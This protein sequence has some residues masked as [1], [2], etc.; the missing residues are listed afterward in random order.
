MSVALKP[1]RRNACDGLKSKDVVVEMGCSRRLAEL[2]FRVVTGRSI[3][4]EILSVRIERAKYLLEHSEKSIAEIAAAC[5][6]GSANAL[7]KVFA[8]ETGKNPLAWR[9]RAV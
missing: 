9:K 3:L 6:Y 8:V 5:G 1:I 7:R 4:E 2:R